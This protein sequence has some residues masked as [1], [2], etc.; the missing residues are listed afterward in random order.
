MTPVFVSSSMAAVRND[1]KLG[2][3][4]QNLFSHGS[5]GQKS[6]TG[7]QRGLVPSGVSWEEAF[8]ASSSLLVTVTTPV[9]FSLPS[10]SPHHSLFCVL[11]S[12]LMSASLY[13]VCVCSKDIVIGFRAT[14]IIQDDLISRSL[15]SVHPQ[16]RSFSQVPGCERIYF[17]ATV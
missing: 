5:G 1:D 15:I 13:S 10:L 17:E 16:I 11:V 9:A 6:E 8:L 14:R 3:L 2:G 12:S 7:C 4:E